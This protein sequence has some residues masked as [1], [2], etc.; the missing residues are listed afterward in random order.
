MVRILNRFLVF[1][2]LLVVIISCSNDPKYE[3]VIA[4]GRV[5]DPETKLDGIRYVGINTG[6]IS[7]ISKR[8]LRGLKT[9]DAS[10]LVVAPGFIDVHSHTPTLLG[11]HVNLLDGVTTQLDLEAGS[12]P[13][14]FYGE[15]FRDGAQINYGSSVGHWAVRTKVIEGIDMPYIFS[16]NKV[17]TMAGSTWMQTATAEQIEQMRVLLNRGL[18]E[19][20]LGIGVLLD[21]MTKAVSDAELRMLF[22]VASARDVP[23]YIHVRRG[24]TGDP[25]GLIEVIDLAVET[26]APL[27]VCHITHNAMGSIGDWLAMIDE[28]N[29]A[30]ANITTETLS[31]A[32][33]GTSISADVFRRRDWKGIFDISYEDVQWVATGEWLT[34]DTWDRYAEEQPTGMVNHHYVKE[35][36]VETALQW[37][38]MMVSTDALP[39]IDTSIP[40]NP[41]IAG[42]FSRVLG[43]YVR[44][45]KILSLQEG[46]AKLS[47][48]QAQWMEQ[49]SPLF[50][51]KGRIQ[52]GADGD[53]VIFD[54]KTVTANAVYGDPYLQ[55]TGIVHV[56]VAGEVVVQD[57][58]RIEGISPGKK[59]LGSIS[60]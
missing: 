57:S 34:K 27:F 7:Q 16:G 23:I 26:G 45:R 54:P 22:E 25:A 58:V 41:N 11:Q 5:I 60:P 42:T 12:F 9:I 56:L 33:G 52:L 37:P 15:H 30:G 28:A 53:I 1:L 21:Y 48:Y 39:A 17:L 4:H 14:S 10:G 32:A 18:D 29:L 51:K 59:L 19:G 38:R 49:A 40:T 6:T 31:Y 47:L 8:P 35:D 20:G 55:P 44:E 36:W 46:L 3:L 2:F 24:Y 43:H 13:V 50:K